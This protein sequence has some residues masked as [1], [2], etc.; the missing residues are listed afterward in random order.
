ML[1]YFVLI[2]INRRN[3]L[4]NALAHA[5]NVARKCGVVLFGP[6]FDYTEID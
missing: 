6:L 2:K 3:D 1:T 4:K 5:K